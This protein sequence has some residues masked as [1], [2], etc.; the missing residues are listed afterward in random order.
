MAAVWLVCGWTPAQAQPLEWQGRVGL[1]SVYSVR[2]LVLGQGAL[3][4][5]GLEAYAPS[6]WGLGASALLLRDNQAR[7]AQGW[8][9]RLAYAPPSGEAC[10]PFVQLRQDRFVH[11]DSLQVWGGSHGS[12][13]WQC[14]DRWSLTLNHDRLRA[15]SLAATSLD[16]GLQWPLAPGWSL[17]AGLGHAWLRDAPAYGY[18]QAGLAWQA[19][20][21]RWQVARQG[22]LA[23]ARRDYGPSA[24]PRWLASVVFGF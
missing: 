12:L 24:G 19:G 2:G 16:L 20:A 23:S 8:G 18:A 22:L 11:T 4:F 6:G 10:R 21:W 5:A 7:L 1:A 3:G 17:D 13:G 9:W 15:R 14:D